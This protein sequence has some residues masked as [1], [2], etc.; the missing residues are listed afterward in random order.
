MPQAL[1]PKAIRLAL[2]LACALTAACSGGGGYNSPAPATAAA[3]ASTSTSASTAS[4]SSSN[5]GTTFGTGL[6][7]TVAA[8]VAASFGTGSRQTATSTTPTFDG[9][10]GAYPANATFPLI[11]TSLQSAS[12]G[13]TATAPQ[14][15]TLTVISTN[16]NSANFQIVIPS[17]NVNTTLTYH[18]NIVQNIDGLNWGYSYV[19]AGMWSQ[20]TSSGVLQSATAFSSGYETPPSAVPTTGSASFAGYATAYVYKP[21]SGA[22]M[23]VYVDGTANLAVNFSSGQV[24]GALT[25][26]R[27]EGGLASIG[28]TPWN[29]VSLNA[30][31]AAG[32]NRFSGTAAATSAPGTAMGL[33]GSATGH[34]DGGFY[35][36]AAQ[37]LGAVWSLN[38]GTGSAV[39]TVVA[40]H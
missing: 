1:T 36:P 6:T 4:A 30:S 7:G 5:F 37:N 12:S 17:L 39:G 8:P 22:I 20:A 38:D 28:P 11:A 25:Q 29:D 33:S 13:L 18:T 23:G 3:T 9:S 26:M 10:N 14:D 27:E 31:I 40:K 16:A 34:I 21:N 2:T 32:S 24:T 35:G 15:A 19:N